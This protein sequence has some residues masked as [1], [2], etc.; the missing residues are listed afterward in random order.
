MKTI[1]TT[2]PAVVGDTVTIDETA[3]N[4]FVITEVAPRKN[5]I[6]RRS[7]KL[8]KQFQIIASNIDRVFIL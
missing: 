6:I 8:S 2:N 3:P 4:E 1:T 7:K 5:Y